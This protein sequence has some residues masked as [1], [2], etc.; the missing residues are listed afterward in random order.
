MRVRVS[1]WRRVGVCTYFPFAKSSSNFMIKIYH[2]N[3][4]HNILFCVDTKG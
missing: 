1:D 2:I 3:Q 4:N